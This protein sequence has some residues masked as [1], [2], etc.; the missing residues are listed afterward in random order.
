MISV[1]SLL[2]SVDSHVIDELL[3]IMQY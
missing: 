3:K 2:S 1:V